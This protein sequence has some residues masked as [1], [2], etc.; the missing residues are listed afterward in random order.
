MK[1]SPKP[2]TTS[3]PVKRG[4]RFHAGRLLVFDDRS[5]TVA[6]PWPELRAWRK[7]ISRGV[8]RPVR[9]EI[10]FGLGSVLTSYT[11]RRR[12]PT[13]YRVPPTDE[14][15]EHD[16]PE[17]ES[18]APIMDEFARWTLRRREEERRAVEQFLASIPA[19]VRAIVGA[20]GDRHWHVASMV[21][22]CPD[23]LELVRSNPAL[24]YCLAS[25]WVFHPQGM[26]WPMRSIRR[27]LPKRR[28]DIAGWL[29]F[30]AGDAAVNILGKIPPGACGI[31]RLLGLRTLLS[32]RDDMKWLSHVEQLSGPILDLLTQPRFNAV[33]TR[34]FVQEAART[35]TT[36]S[37]GERSMGLL[38]DTFWMACRLDQRDQLRLS[39]VRQLAREHD[40]L[41]S[42][43]RDR[44]RGGPDVTFDEPPVSGTESILPIR[45]SEE[46]LQEGEEQDSCVAGYGQAV[47]RGNCYIY[48]VL[49]PERATLSLVKDHA[50]WR[51]GE[52]SLRGNCP[53]AQA[54]VAAVGNWLEAAS[55]GPFPVSLRTDQLAT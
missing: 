33:C 13:R 37:D 6:R 19:E 55:G 30:P 24:A 49:S 21:L 45:S 40:R 23:A 48:R 35:W 18:A 34:A 3:R 17:A 53:V 50:G 7:L 9:P 39:S 38:S 16:T 42:L 29:G 32:E 4:I 26:S 41:A 15:I 52:L 12:P 14:P 22:R 47:I 20:F 2:G 1:P 31:R 10:H 43:E 27:L 46:L 44:I 25:A 11:R 8:W 28:R 54:T 5:V 51:L 36:D